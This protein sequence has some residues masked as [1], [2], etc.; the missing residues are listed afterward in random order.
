M[1]RASLTRLFDPGPCARSRRALRPGDA[2]R[3]TIDLARHAER[4]ELHAATGSPSTTTCRASPAR[5][6]LSSSAH[7]AAA[8]KRIRVG[9][10][11]IMLPNHAPLVIAEQ[12]G[13]LAELFPGRIDLGLGRAPGTDQRT[14]GRCAC[15]PRKPTI[16][17]N[18]VMELQAFLAAPTADQTDPRRARLRHAG[19][20]LDP[21]IEPLRRAARG[22]AGAALRIRLA[23]RARCA[24][25]C[26]ADLP[27]DVQALRADRDVLR[28]GRVNVFAA[29]TDAE[30]RRLFTSAQQRSLAMI[31]GARGY[32]PPPVDDIEALV[33]PHGEGAGRAHAVLLVRGLARHG[34]RAGWTVHRARQ[35]WTR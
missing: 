31:S 20:A 35:G 32:L 17:P 9:S 30:A 18:D 8:T 16:F 24:D 1:T 26:A 10:G 4:H 23:F 13:T 3:N 15:N 11:G 29:D 19:S 7:V 5:R 28:H 34:P 14:C 12:F 21:R 2:I 22:D 27:A 33:E 25:A 6:R